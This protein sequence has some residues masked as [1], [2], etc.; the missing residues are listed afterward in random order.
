MKE[1]PFGIEFV[2][3]VTITDAN[4]GRQGLIDA[5]KVKINN[6]EVPA[7]GFV[8]CRYCGKSTSNLREKDYRYHYGYCKYKDKEYVG[9]SDEVYAEVFL[10]REVK[11]E[12]LK[13]LL[14]VQDFNSEA[15]IKMFQAGIELGLKKYFNGNPQH[16][17]ISEYREFNHHTGK[18]DRYLVLYD[19]VP[20]GTGYLEKLFDFSNF[21]EL[22]RLAYQEI[23][24]CSCQHHG[25]DGCYRC[26]YSYSNQYYQSDLSR[27]RAE[28][29]FAEIVQKSESWESV[30]QGLGKITAS[31]Q[32][33]ESELED[34][35]VRSL[36][37]LADNKE[38][39][40][41]EDIKEEGLVSYILRYKNELSSL[42]YHIRPQVVL[43]PQYGIQFITRTDFLFVCTSASFNGKV[44]YEL[45]MVPRIA[46]Y[47]DGFQYHASEE[48]NRFVNDLEKRKGIIENPQY[49]TWTLTWEDVEKFDSGFL[50]DNEIRKSEDFLFQLSKTDGFKETRNKML[51]KFGANDPIKVYEARN[52]FERF[53]RLLKFPIKNHE[54][55]RYTWG[56]NLVTFHQKLFSPSYHPDQLQKAFFE[57]EY[58]D[59][60]ALDQR[61]QDAL[62]PFEGVPKSS[63]FEMKAMIHLKKWQIFYHYKIRSSE[64]IDKEEWNNFWVLF[65][66]LQFAEFVQETTGLVK[67]E[68]GYN[69]EQLLGN[70]PDEVYHE[71]LAKLYTKGYLKSEED[72]I[73]L[74]TAL[75]DQG[76]TLAEAELIIDHLKLVIGPID[77]QSTKYFE[78]IGYRIESQEELK[79]KE[80]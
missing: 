36:K 50:G 46:V 6:T 7:H 21:S 37:I 47:L 28:K 72:E 54:G 12:V 51:G 25:K 45:D 57:E 41:F 34:R 66:M 13:I 10:F 23:K 60:Y 43:G 77:E 76:N 29:R 4:L 27:E 32:I 22:L 16:I 61:T 62:I 8:T 63:L 18:F 69:L 68:S 71:V 38:E 26:I 20:G 58:W 75:D 55:F 17:A 80:I 14:P 73:R 1:I 44:L 35:F 11:T 15:E 39:W 33:E 59:Q 74:Y 53:L 40:T 42:T 24:N 49:L 5:R 2:K 64:Q 52:N 70:F 30:P 56:L 19:T 9:K 67:E 31:G 3:N 78:N 65:N 79:N 48:N